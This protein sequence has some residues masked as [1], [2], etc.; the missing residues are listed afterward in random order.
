MRTGLVVDAGCDLPEQLLAEEKVVVLPIAVRIGDQ[1]INDQRQDAVSMQFLESGLAKDAA[2]A[3]TIPFTVE[4]I[5]ELFLRQLVVDYD[6]VMVETITSTRSPI[7]ERCVQASFKILSEYHGHRNAGDGR[8]PFNMRVTDTGSLFAGQSLIAWETIRMRREGTSPNLIRT[9]VDRVVANTHAM[10]VT[11]DL[12]YVRSRAR[13]KGDRSVGLLSAALGSALDIKPWL[14]CNRGQTRPVAKI[15]GYEAAC[16]RMMEHVARRCGEDLL[17][18]AITLSYGGDLAEVR[19]LP[20]YEALRAA[21]E[22][23]SIPLV[24]SVM[25][26]TGIINT[27]PGTLSL[28][29]AQEGAQHFA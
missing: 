19:Q 27:G 3:E 17:V 2:E 29:Y 28:A 25:G 20:G 13:A 5:A 21:C 10:L 6:Y 15:R 1:V 23:A 16:Q 4:Q 12:Y 22:D 9:R 14:Y 24:E 11:P 7:H 18:P 8:G 26:L